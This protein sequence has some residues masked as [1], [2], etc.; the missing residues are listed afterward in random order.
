MA[1][2]P[3]VSVALALKLAPLVKDTVPVAPVIPASTVMLPLLDAFVLVADNVPLSE[4]PPFEPP[5]PWLT[6]DIVPPVPPATAEPG[7]PALAVSVL[8]IVMASA[9]SEVILITPPAPV[10]APLT[11]KVGTNSRVPEVAVLAVR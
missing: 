4:I 7:V 8:E 10:P 9:L 11:L 1:T 6:I 2:L 5:C 3:P